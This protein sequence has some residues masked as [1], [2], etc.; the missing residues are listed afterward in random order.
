MKQSG[1]NGVKTLTLVVCAALA[2]QA[3]AAVNY[4]SANY[5]GS[6]PEGSVRFIIKYK[7]KSQSQQMM[8][9]RSTT[10]VM[11]N[12]NI[13]IAGFN[14]QF[15]R[16]MTIG[17]GI[18]AVPDLK[19]TKEAHLVMDTIASNPDVE[20][21]EVDR[22][23]RPF[24]APND[25]FYNDQW[26]Y[27][28]EYGVKADKVW[29]RGITGKGVTVAVVDT[30]I[31]NHPD[32]NAN[33][34]PGSGYDFIQEAEI[35]QD[36]D[37]RDSNPADAGDWHSNWACGKYPDPRYEK[38][39]S[40]WHGSHVAGTIAAVTNNRIGVSGVAYDAKI[41]PVRVLG[42][43]GGYNSDINE[44]MYWAAGGH[45]DGVPDNKHPAQVINMS[46]GGPGVCGS[47]EQTLI[48]RATQLGATIIVAAGND[49]ID[50]YGVTPASCDNILTVGATTSNGTRAYF[51]N[52]GSVVDISAPGAGITST[53][54]SGARYP[55]GPSYSLMDGTSMATPHVAGVAAL[56]ISAAN[57]VNKE[58]TPAQVRDV[59][60]RTVSSF[61]GTPDRRIGAGIVDADA[62]VNAV[63]DGN[64]VER[65]IDELKPQAEYRNPQ[66]KLIRDYQMMFSEIKVNGRPGNTKFAVVKADI[67]HTDPSQLKL[68]LVSPKGYEYAV[69]Y[70]N[71]KNKSSELI[72]FPRDEQMN[73]YWRLKIVDTKRGV[74][75]YTRGWSVAF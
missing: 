1:I 41:V 55:S 37:G 15:V 50:A 26:H 59:L 75:G 56:V 28:S 31:V 63:L 72:T 32:L 12:N 19:T 23:L 58:M 61:N 22:W 65:P 69:D 30:G 36:G 57:S 48:N 44:G 71:I 45:I 29:D 42:R 10:S 6:Q 49:N 38:R 17:A 27:Y 25:P 33:V 47:T 74:T 16:T 11:N 70:D 39:N 2:S 3:Y 5:I 46:L 34:I 54:N 35:A 18:F 24:A 51:S 4:E 62:A 43:C 73:G 66:I 67:R 13:T 7:D 60:V 64:V 52:H 20:Y 14:A 40:S 9:N 53:V 8:T 68:R 21:V